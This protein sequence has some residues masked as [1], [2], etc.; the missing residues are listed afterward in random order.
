[1][2]S[3]HSSIHNLKLGCWNINGLSQDKL[4]DDLFKQ[5]V[6]SLDLCFFIETFQTDFSHNIYNNYTFH[7]S[8]HRISKKGRPMGGIIITMKES[9]RNS[10]KIIEST[11]K[12]MVWLE[13]NS[14]HFGLK[15]PL[16]ICIIYIPPYES[17]IY[18][19]DKYVIYDMLENYIVK[20]GSIGNILIMGDLN[21]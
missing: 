6:D 14:T 13:L 11:C 8:T 18:G 15:K 9:L 4:S 5:F 20:Y 1:M 3:S 2:Y 16:Y 19:D 17:K 21:G 12:H 7:K 10:I